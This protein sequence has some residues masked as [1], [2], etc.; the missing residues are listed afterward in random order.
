MRPC[1]QKS[2]GAALLNESFLLLAETPQS[3]W[4]PTFLLIHPRPMHPL[5]LNGEQPEAPG[6]LTT[7]GDIMCDHIWAEA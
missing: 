1:V 6:Q 4:T 2:P 5:V 7:A 3:S